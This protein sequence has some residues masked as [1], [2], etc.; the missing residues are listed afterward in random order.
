MSR[1]NDLQALQNQQLL[2]SKRKTVF[3]LLEHVSFGGK[4]TPPAV[5]FVGGV[6]KVP[7]DEIRSFFSI[8]LPVRHEYV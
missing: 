3:L 7:P 4:V 2:V 8:Q 6:V 1:K 5:W